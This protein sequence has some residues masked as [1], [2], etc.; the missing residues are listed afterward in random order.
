[1]VNKVSEAMNRAE[2]KRKISHQLTSMGAVLGIC[3]YID[4][5]ISPVIPM[6]DEE[7]NFTRLNWYQEVEFLKPN[8]FK[9]AYRMSLPAF[10]SLLYMLYWDI[11]TEPKF[12]PCSKMPVIPELRLAITLRYLAGANIHDLWLRFGVS[13]TEVY[14]SIW[15]TVDA[16]NLRLHYKT[17]FCDPCTLADLESGFAAKST[18]QL[19]RGCVGAIDGLQVKIRSPSKKK[20]NIDDPKS[21]FCRKGF[22]SVNVQATCDS[23]RRFI[24]FDIRWPGSTSDTIAWM[25]TG[26]YKAVFNRELPEPYFFVGDAA[27]PCSERMLTPVPGS[28]ETI[29]KWADSFNFHQ[30]QLRIN[31]ECAFG[32]L[33][34]R[35][36]VLWKPLEVRF[37]RVPPLIAC[38]MRVHNFCIDYALLHSSGDD[39]IPHHGERGDGCI[40]I[41]SGKRPICMR[42]RFDKDG[43]PVD[44]LSTTIRHRLVEN[45]TKRDMFIEKLREHGQLRPSR[46]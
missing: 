25:T 17:N 5:V 19:L 34:R 33:V 42:P 36:G 40:V 7:R 21:F 24:D 26:V 39:H 6:R 11:F 20:D 10:N 22:S 35:F 13:V 3:M 29:G 31:I 15:M 38:C 12:V 9:R 16:I 41:G 28:V 44:L 32:M 45:V 43:I 1:M 37:K 23:A 8:E 14:K 27:Y 30:S 4:A 18:R 46:R 2:K